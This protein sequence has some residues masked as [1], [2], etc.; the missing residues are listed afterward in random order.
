[1]TSPSRVLQGGSHRLLPVRDGHFGVSVTL[2]PRLRLVQRHEHLPALQSHGVGALLPPLGTDLLWGRLVRH[3][4]RRH[5]QGPVEPLAGVE[6]DAVLVPRA[7]DARVP[8]H[9]LNV[10]LQ[11]R[12]TVVVAGVVERVE[13][14][15]VA[16]HDDVAFVAFHQ[17]PAAFSKRRRRPDVKSRRCRH[18]HVSPVVAHSQHGGSIPPPAS[19]SARR[20]NRNGRENSRGQKETQ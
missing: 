9:L 5:L 11:Q 7:H 6:G 20:K 10:A 17:L 12:P 15:L 8:A 3:S 2:Q 1:M 14:F 19:G 13:A 4:R 18:C 16:K